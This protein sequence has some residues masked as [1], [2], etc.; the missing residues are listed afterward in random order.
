MIEG[1]FSH[2]LAQFSCGFAELLYFNFVDLCT[3]IRYKSPL[4]CLTHFIMTCALVVMLFHQIQ[5]S[6]CRYLS[7]IHFDVE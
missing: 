3:H 7:R 5:A 2:S 6:G 1:F 4:I